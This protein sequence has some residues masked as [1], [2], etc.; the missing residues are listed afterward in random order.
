M[1]VLHITTDYP[2]LKDGK[3]VNY[4]GLGLCVSQMVSGLMDKGI[5]VDVLSRRDKNTGDIE[6]ISDN[7]YRTWYFSPTKSRNWKLTHAFTMIPTLVKLLAKNKYDI[8]HM[9]NPPAAFMAIG[10]AVK[11]GAKT[12]V[13]M[14]GP[15]AKVREK[16]KGL[17]ESI[18]AMALINTDYITFDSESLMKEY[19]NSDRF[20]A[21]PN[22]VDIDKFRPLV[23]HKCRE[24]FNLD[25]AKKSYLYSGRHVYGKNIDNIRKLAGD[26]PDYE[27]LIAGTK[28]RMDDF[29]FSNLKYIGTLSND[30]MP[31]LYNACDAI[32]LD[33]KAEGMSRAVLESMACERPAF[34]S[35]IPANREAVGIDG[36]V[37]DDYDGLRDLV[38]LLS[39]ADLREMG[40]GSREYIEDKFTVDKRI[41][42]FI[43][44]YEY[45]IN[46]G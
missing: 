6:E 17:A 44:V 22:A 28:S 12:L 41:D 36:G 39:R 9:H 38:E 35:N 43:K 30:D 8:V 23:R 14:H 37:F 19:G 27:F 46:N 4:G 3:I 11:Y 45:I 5:D 20:F 42:N 26:F 18:E 13:T 10:I 40:I 21:I 32:I 29:E 1:R 31:T 25:D 34:V 16:M 2:Y 33:S 15:W 7:I 24:Y